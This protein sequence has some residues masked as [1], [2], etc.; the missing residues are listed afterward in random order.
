MLRCLF[1][2]AS[3]RKFATFGARSVAA[4][5]LVTLVCLA[6][7]FARAH[8]GHEDGI[9]A[10]GA[11]P[12]LPRLATGSEV[13]ELVAILDRERLT[14]YLDR[15]DDNSP[16]TDATLT[17]LVE[18][19]QVPAE[20]T[21]NGTYVATS[22]RFNARG[23]IELVFD[24]RAS[25]GADLLIGKLFLPASPSFTEGTS[26]SAP[27]YER[28]WSALR[29]GA[30]DHLALLVFILCTGLIVGAACSRVGLRALPVILVASAPFLSTRD[31]SDAHEG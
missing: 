17:V 12:S 13:Y 16:V 9:P 19:E 3:G 24:I 26:V 2:P 28:L 22:Q 25:A 10:A 5:F 31:V 7:F 1:G 11:T 6:A 8:E 21:P 30:E 15:F 27:L 20:A 23:S 29:H 18:G 14:I 4:F